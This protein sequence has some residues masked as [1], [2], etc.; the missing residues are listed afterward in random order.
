MQSGVTFLMRKQLTNSFFHYVGFIAKVCLPNIF[1]HVFIATAIKSKSWYVQ[2]LAYRLMGLGW[3][4]YCANC[5]LTMSYEWIRLRN[6][7]YVCQ[8]H[9]SK[10]RIRCSIVYYN[11]NWNINRS[12][13]L[14]KPSSVQSYEQ[15]FCTHHSLIGIIRTQ[16]FSCNVQHTI[17][18][19]VF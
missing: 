14:W 18:Q 7:R 1:S 13:E 11:Y 4:L 17:A 9:S 10:Y 5:N 16:S 2:F 8:V 6:V 15:I 12:F 3:L 19:Y